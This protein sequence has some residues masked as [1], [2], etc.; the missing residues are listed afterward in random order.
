MPAKS[1]V[2]PFLALAV[3]VF[4]APAAVAKP[5]RAP[6]TEEKPPLDAWSAVWHTAAV[7][8]YSSCPGTEPG[9]QEAFTLA[10]KASEKAITATE[11]P[12]QSLPRKLTGKPEL[13]GKQWVLELRSADGK[14]GM[15]VFVTDDGKLA[16][17]RV[18]VRSAGK[19]TLCSVVYALEGQRP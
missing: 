13:R 2:V 12:E 4:A 1:V 9:H 15:D 16:G 14:N 5:K 8:E 7:V 3:L 6:S 17:T 18:I 10:V 11:Q 19:R